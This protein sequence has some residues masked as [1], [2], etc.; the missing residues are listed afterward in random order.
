MGQLK[1]LLIHCF[2]TPIQMKV[3]PEMI[4]DW[5]RAPRKNKDGTITY[6]GRTYKSLD[7]ANVSEKHKGKWGRG[8]DRVGYSDLMHSNGKVENITPYD[9]DDYVQANEMTWGATGV[10][11]IARHIGVEGGKYSEFGLGSMTDAQITSLMR[12]CR[13]FIYHHPEA[14]IGGHNQFSKKACPNFDTVDF[15]EL[16]GIPEKNILQHEHPLNF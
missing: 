12:Y 4:D 8:W 6:L 14:K 2:D 15:C 9:E 13:K 7:Y 10:N 11:S 1:L 16:V 5:H 3:T